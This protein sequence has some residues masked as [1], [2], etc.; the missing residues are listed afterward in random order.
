MRIWLDRTKV[1]ELSA[2]LN[3]IELQVAHLKGLVASYQAQ[4]VTPSSQ[5]PKPEPFKPE[6]K[7]CSVCGKPAKRED[8]HHYW[9]PRSEMVEGL[10]DFSMDPK[11]R[12]LYRFCSSRCYDVYDQKK[13]RK[14][15]G[16]MDIKVIGENK[17]GNKYT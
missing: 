12:A 17:M 7:L 8:M 13:G 5:Q 14:S 1:N 3:G 4:P 2:T 15:F 10:T 11:G 16:G 6:P 9:V